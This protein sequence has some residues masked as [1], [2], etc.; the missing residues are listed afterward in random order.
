[1]TVVPKGMDESTG[2]S[3]NYVQATSMKD[4]DA[5]KTEIAEKEGSVK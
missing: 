4:N 2:D 3:G 5:K 1:M